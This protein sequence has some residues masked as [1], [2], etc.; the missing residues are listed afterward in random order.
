MVRRESEAFLENTGVPS[1]FDFSTGILKLTISNC[2][3]DS[4]SDRINRSTSISCEDGSDDRLT[5]S[6]TDMSVIF[7]VTGVG[8]RSEGWH[9]VVHFGIC[10]VIVRLRLRVSVRKRGQIF[11]CN[12]EARMKIVKMRVF[13]FA[14]KS[15]VSP[16]EKRIEK[17]CRSCT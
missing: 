5:M 12:A 8:V 14:W 2:V 17:S 13:G 6:K 10:I 15:N 1:S 11:T 4:D 16:S 9:T 7:I 3:S